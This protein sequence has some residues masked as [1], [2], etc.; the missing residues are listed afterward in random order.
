MKKI[1]YNYI[2]YINKIYKCYNCK[3]KRHDT[4][5]RNKR[6]SKIKHWII[7]AISGYYWILVDES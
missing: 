6:R 1:T 4:K 2:T 3:T 5:T 7:R